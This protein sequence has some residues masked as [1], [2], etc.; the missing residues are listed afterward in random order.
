MNPCDFFIKMNEVESM[1]RDSCLCLLCYDKHDLCYAQQLLIGALCLTHT[2]HLFAVHVLF[3]PCCLQRC[4]L[5]CTALLWHRQE[6]TFTLCSLQVEFANGSWLIRCVPSGNRCC[7]D[8]TE[9]SAAMV[10]LWMLPRTRFRSESHKT[11]YI[12]FVI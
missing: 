10:F 8:N 7:R 5:H 6:E 11:V 2:V 3:M 9:K 1:S 12:E 4:C